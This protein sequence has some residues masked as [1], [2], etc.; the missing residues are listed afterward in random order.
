[1][2]EVLELPHKLVTCMRGAFD[3]SMGVQKTL[4]S[5]QLQSSGMSTLRVQKHVTPVA[6]SEKQHQHD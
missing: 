6:S 1:M 4:Q 5:H 3:T 2:V